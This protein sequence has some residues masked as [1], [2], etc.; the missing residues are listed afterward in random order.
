MLE[1]S[2]KY[3]GWS[4]TGWRLEFLSPTPDG[5]VNYLAGQ[6]ETA[7]EQCIKRLIQAVWRRVQAC[8]FSTPDLPD[9]LAGRKQFEELLLKNL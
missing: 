5:R 4:I 1:A 2:G 9:T 8:D 3:P 6:F 7:E